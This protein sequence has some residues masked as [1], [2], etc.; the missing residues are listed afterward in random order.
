M[1]RNGMRV[2]VFEKDA[3]PGLSTVCAG[4]MSADV[5]PFIEL[6]DEIIERRLSCLRLIVGTRVREWRFTDPAYLTIDRGRF[7]R[8]LARRACGHE[9]RRAVVLKGRFSS[10]QKPDQRF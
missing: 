8:H 6:P 3:E 5:A 9:V 1:A 4:G 2:V 7:D 10:G